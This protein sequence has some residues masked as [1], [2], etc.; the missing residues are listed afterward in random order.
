GQRMMAI[1]RQKNG[2]PL[3]FERQAVIIYAAVNGYLGRVPALQVGEFE[4]KF[5]D[6][7]DAHR[8]E[9]L[10]SIRKAKDIASQTDGELKLQLQKFIEI[11]GW[12]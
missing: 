2:K 12:A 10:D 5:L 4:Q 1:L 9:V 3:A 6:H 8:P 7:L 11:H